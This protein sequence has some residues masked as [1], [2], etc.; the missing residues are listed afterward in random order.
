MHSEFVY[1]NNLYSG[2][3]QPIWVRNSGVFTFVP[4]YPQDLLLLLFLRRNSSKTYLYN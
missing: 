1:T 3:P 2:Y 4:S